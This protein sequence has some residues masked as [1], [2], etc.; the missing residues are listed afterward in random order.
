MR[1]VFNLK[2]LTLLVPVSLVIAL[3]A[4]VDVSTREELVGEMIDKVAPGHFGL[5][6]N[7]TIAF[8]L[9]GGSA[10]C[11]V[12][13][14]LWSP[15]P[16]RRESAMFMG[17][18]GLAGLWLGWD[19]AYVM[20]EQVLPEHLGVGQ[21]TISAAYGVGLLALL[22]RFRRQLPGRYASLLGGAL[23]AMAASE[24]VDQFA[25]NGSH[26]VLEE[27]LKFVG[28]YFWAAFLALRGMSSLRAEMHP[29]VAVRELAAA[30]LPDGAHGDSVVP[31]AGSR[32][33]AGVAGVGA[34][35]RADQ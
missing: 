34:T 21:S 3:I 6:S 18:M 23:L 7:L 32:R 1:S 20:H 25:T 10:A 19:D 33:G 15:D 13:A 27:S 31:A 5:V 14:A 16:G 11:V 8:W 22:A 2:T 9:I 29:P 24:I 4:A 30:G 17:T 12:A 26:N 28:V 35:G